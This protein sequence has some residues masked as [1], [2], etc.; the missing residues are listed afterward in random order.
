MSN[1]N[2]PVPGTVP[3]YLVC[4]HESNFKNMHFDAIVIH[5]NE[6]WLDLLKKRNTSENVSFVHVGDFKTTE[7]AEAF[8]TRMN[9]LMR[10]DEEAK[11]EHE[12]NRA[13][14]YQ[15]RCEEL[16]G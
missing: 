12:V 8:T 15:A 5:S 6:Q 1:I 11:A 9:T 7:E 13:E 14:E 10:A 16:W 2:Y 3:V 4:D